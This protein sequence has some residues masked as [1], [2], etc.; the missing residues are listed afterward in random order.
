MENTTP[1]FPTQGVTPSKTGKKSKLP[2]II[3]ILVILVLVGGVYLF[4][5]AKKSS[6]PQ[7]SGVITTNNVPSPT[8]K[9]QIDKMSVKIEVLNG[10]GTPGQAGKAADALKKGGYSSDNIKTDNAPNYDFTTTSVAAKPGFEDIAND[11][12][13]VLSSAFDSVEIDPS[14]LASDSQFD[15][16]VT[17]GGKKYVVPTSSPTPTGASPS[18]TPTPSLSP[19]STPAANLT[20]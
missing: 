15:I 7:V 11:I 1:A 12:K 16:I 6:A 2:I 14:Q 18:E 19:T 13:T 9:P 8:T 17:T 10:T 5:K 4:R 20:P 3:F